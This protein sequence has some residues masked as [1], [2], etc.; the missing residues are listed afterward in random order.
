M[1][2]HQVDFVVVGGWAIEVQMAAEGTAVP[3][4]P[5]QDIDIAP[6]QELGN[7]AR[8]SDALRELSADIYST[9]GR[10]R[11]D[12]DA[13]SFL[14]ISVRNLMCDIGRFDLTFSPTNMGTFDDMLPNAVEVW[15]P[16]EGESDPVRV[17]CADLAAIY[18]SKRSLGRAKDEAAVR[19][20]EQVLDLAPS[21]APSHHPEQD[22][23]E[24]TEPPPDPELDRLRRQID[25][26]LQRAQ[27]RTAQ[28][29]IEGSDL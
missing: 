21:P 3:Y 10:F 9:A 20:L 11:F 29:G 2:R 17:R 22:P 25:E 18:R 5:T 26:L 24:H 8:L 7:L 15:V 14:G 12:H 4:P 16:V 27:R 19:F 13:E 1:A 6:R 28:T 23:P